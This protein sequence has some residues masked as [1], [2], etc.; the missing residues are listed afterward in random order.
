MNMNN[1][2]KNTYVKMQITTALLELL[3]EKPLSD[4]TVSEL[5]NKAE[6]GRVSFYRNY[7]NKEDILKELSSYFSATLQILDDEKKFI[8][9]ISYEELLSNPEMVNGK[10]ANVAEEL[11][12]SS[13]NMKLDL[14]CYLYQFQR[15]SDDS[16]NRFIRIVDNSSNTERRSLLEHLY[17]FYA[18]CEDNEK[19]RLINKFLEFYS[20]KDIINILYNRLPTDIIYY[21]YLAKEV[22]KKMED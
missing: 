2:Q 1:E 17:K 19:L 22:N 9:K 10:M 13:Y 7:Q 18:H 6:I 5:T 12:S 14:I 11:L 8:D 15:N 16:I 4:I 21:G 3:K 20:I